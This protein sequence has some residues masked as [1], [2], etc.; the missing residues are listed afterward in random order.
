ME[1]TVTLCSNWTFSNDQNWITKLQTSTCSTCFPFKYKFLVRIRHIFHQNKTDE[2]RRKVNTFRIR[3]FFWIIE[4][5][6]LEALQNLCKFQSKNKH[7]KRTVCSPLIDSNHY[8]SRTWLW[9]PTK[10][11]MYWHSCCLPLAHLAPRSH[12][13]LDFLFDD[14]DCLLMGMPSVTLKHKY[15]PYNT[16]TLHAVPIQWTSYPL[17]D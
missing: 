14:D 11:T 10:Y 1:L 9:S 7:V 3:N 4:K 2:V 17:N 5:I 16:N 12:C 15:T 13:L 8:Q 6:Y